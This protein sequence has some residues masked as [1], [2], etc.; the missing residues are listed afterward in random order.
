MRKVVGKEKEKEG[1]TLFAIL[2][3]LNIQRDAVHKRMLLFNV[4]LGDLN[5]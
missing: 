1:K 2:R 4:H 3:N 5:Y